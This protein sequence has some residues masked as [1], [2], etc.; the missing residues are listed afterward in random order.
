MTTKSYSKHMYLLMFW[1]QALRLLPGSGPSFFELVKGYPILPVHCHDE[2]RRYGIQMKMTRSTCPSGSRYREL[3]QGVLAGQPRRQEAVS[4]WRH[5]PTDDQST[6]RLVEATLAYQQRF[7]ADWVKVTPAGTWQ[8]IDFGLIDAWRGDPI[9]RRDVIQRVIRHPEDWTQLKPVGQQR[10]SARIIA[11][12]E[13]LRRRLP[14][15]VPLLATVF[16][17]SSQ[18]MLLAGHE[19]LIRHLQ[20]YPALAHQGLALLAHDTMRLIDELRAAGANGIHYAVQTA[21]AISCPDTLF[22][23]V[24]LAFDTQALA[25][26]NGA[27]FNV[28][29]LH[30]EMLRS[31]LFEAYAPYPLHFDAGAAGNPALQDT[32][33]SCVMLGAPVP[34]ATM[35]HTTAERLRSAV[36]A[37]RTAMQQRRFMLAPGCSLPLG[38]DDALVD[39]FVAAARECQENGEA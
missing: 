16:S 20:E 21:S 14:A 34:I 37:Q 8:S 24:P 39:A 38:V 23:G 17:P 35:P 18:A 25:S 4:V 27:E 10:F 7:D 5:H 19:L 30:G 31:G 9:G 28:V 22:A 11:A 36:L 3:L 32:P 26:A 33:A 29:H 2:P 15:E 13:Q 12:V 1:V 6:E